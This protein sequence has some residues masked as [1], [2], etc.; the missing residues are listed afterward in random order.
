MSQTNLPVNTVAPLAN[1]AMVMKAMSRAI[2]GNTLERMLVLHGHA[3]YGKTTAAGYAANKLRGYRVECCSH[4]SRKALLQSVLHEMGIP[5]AHAIND[6]FNQAVEQLAKSARPLIIDEADHLVRNSTIELIRDIHDK[7]GA[8][9]L[10]SGEEGLP[11]KL[12]RWARVHSR[13]LEFIPAQPADLSDLEHLARLYCP[14]VDITADWL[15]ELHQQTG[16]NTRRVCVNLNRVRGEADHIGSISLASWG[17][18]G[19]YTGTSPSPR[20][21]V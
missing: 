2:E 8:V 17:D 12:E 3:G 10:L 14:G 11:K 15:K 1:V 9:V 19:W 5:A 21:A 6:M 18:R 7:S 13:I 20:R 4:W 16:G